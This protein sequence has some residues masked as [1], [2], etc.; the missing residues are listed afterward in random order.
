LHVRSARIA[1]DGSFDP[2]SGEEG[3]ECDVVYGAAADAE[4]Y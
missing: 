3:K 4:L 2:V 1:H